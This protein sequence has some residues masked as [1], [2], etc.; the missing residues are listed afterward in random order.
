MN[1]KGIRRGEGLVDDLPVVGDDDQRI[2]GRGRATGRCACSG[3]RVEVEL[4]DVA[5]RPRLHL[6][7]VGRRCRVP[8]P[9]DRHKAPVR[10]AKRDV[11]AR[12]P[13]DALPVRDSHV[14]R[15]LAKHHHVRERVRGVR[16]PTC[17]PRTSRSSSLA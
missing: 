10:A 12:R 16:T 9:V 7:R 6:R 15:H 2:G 14:A 3:G 8:R 13:A 5:V 4:R 11:I 1:R 17:H